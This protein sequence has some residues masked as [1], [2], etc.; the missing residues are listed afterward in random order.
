M[1]LMRRVLLSSALA[2]V[3]F[4]APSVHAA[5]LEVSG[6]LPY[7]REATSTARALEK[8]DHLTEINPFVYD[9]KSDGTLHDYAGIDKEPWISL[10]AE[11][12]RKKV[13]VIPT[14]MWSDA[15]AMHRILGNYESRVALEDEILAEVTKHGFDG[16]DIDFEGKWY[17]TR[18]HFSTFLKGLQ[19]RF[20][21]K[22]VMCT[23]EA[24][25]PLDSRYESTPPE[26][27]G[28]YANDYKAIHKYC[29][30]VRIMAYDQGAID[31]R[32]NRAA[33]Q[34]PYVP[35]ADVRWVEKTIKEA[36]KFIPKHKIS[37]GVP[38]Y[39]Y[40]YR[41]TPLSEQGFRYER[42]WALNP[43]Y[44]HDLI[45]EYGVVA[46]RNAAGEL[47]FT[48]IPT[49]NEKGDPTAVPHAFQQSQVAAVSLGAINQNTVGNAAAVVTNG[50]YNIV[51]W[52]DA[53][54]IE[55][56]IKLAKKLGVRGISVFKID[57]GEDPAIWSILPK[58]R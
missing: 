48:Y 41:V 8:L 6:W 40:E 35:V 27:A 47:S 18:D 2:L 45:A 53:K 20:P 15:A 10:I 55:D 14:I 46:K 11:A 23:I 43:K 42:Q 19:M 38:T 37:I 29:D 4:A 28:Q 26:G 1:Y 56:K 13:R 34:A 31:L 51:W 54:A 16:I 25:T 12:K 33:N 7:W 17:E 39:G 58:V 50:T 3:L 5:S 36:L 22:W 21:K 57:G 44:A 49:H 24:R 52:S 9:I 32:L 30:R